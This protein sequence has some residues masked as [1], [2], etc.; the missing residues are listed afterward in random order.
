[1]KWETVD[2]PSLRVF[3]AKFKAFRAGWMRSWVTLLKSRGV[4]L[5]DI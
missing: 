4:E 1:M 5:N 2:A 3:K